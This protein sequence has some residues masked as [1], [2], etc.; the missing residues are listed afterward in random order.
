LLVP[1]GFH[2]SLLRLKARVSNIPK[3]TNRTFKSANH[4]SR[5]STLNEADYQDDDSNDQQNMNKIAQCIASYQTQQPQN[6]QYHSNRPQHLS[7]L[8]D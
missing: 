8:P 1:H 5:S 3:V 2:K 7:L 4:L 6:Y